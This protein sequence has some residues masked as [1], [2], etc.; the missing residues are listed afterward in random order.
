MAN[1]SELT[2]LQAAFV[3]EQHQAAQLQLSSA[4]YVENFLQNYTTIN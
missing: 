3:L 4:L 1:R 2:L